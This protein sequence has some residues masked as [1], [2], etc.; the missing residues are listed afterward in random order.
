MRR[1]MQVLR[2]GHGSGLVRFDTT[3]FRMDLATLQKITHCARALESSRAAFDAAL[4]ETF[5]P[6]VRKEARSFLLR[7]LRP[8]KA[9]RPAPRPRHVS[10]KDLSDFLA[11]CRSLHFVDYAKPDE[12]RAKDRE[13]MAR[14]AAEEPPPPLSHPLTASPPVA[15]PA[16]LREIAEVTFR[17]RREVEFLDHRVGKR[18]VPSH[19]ARHPFDAVFAWRDGRRS[20]EAYFDPVGG[21][22]HQLAPTRRSRPIGTSHWIRLYAAY[23][24]VMWRY[25]HSGYYDTLLLDAGHILTNVAMVAASRGWE[26]GQTSSPEAQ[27]AGAEPLVAEVFLEIELVPRDRRGSAQR[28]RR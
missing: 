21:R 3:W 27:P 12:A 17:N 16:V 14:Y 11:A 25:R 9:A 10:D 22:A 23:E 2:A 5:A 15:L 4:E 28:G 18:G 26:I 6:A 24:R 13:R 8:Q 20:V 7:Q 1:A 19:G